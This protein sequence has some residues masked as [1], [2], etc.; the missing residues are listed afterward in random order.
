MFQITALYMDCEISYAEGFDKEE[1][2]Q[3]CQEGIPE[4][5]RAVMEDITYI[6]LFPS[7]EF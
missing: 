3:E 2:M 4:A 6:I 7:E 1:T 5:Y